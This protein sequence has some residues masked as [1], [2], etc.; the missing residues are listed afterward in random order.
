MKL[1]IGT[2]SLYN[3]LENCPHKAYHIY[4]LKDVP[5]VESPEMKW[6][7]DVHSALEH[8]IAD[9]TPLPE[10]MTAAEPTAATLHR[11]KDRFDVH[12][13]QKIGMSASGEPCDFWSADCWFRGK[14]DVSV[15]NDDFKAAW[16]LDW[17]TG[18]VREEP[19]EL[20][21]QALLTK[22][23]H[24]DLDLICGNYFWLQTGK[25]GHRYT[26]GDHDKVFGKLHDL[27][28]ELETYAEKGDW[29]KRKNPLCGWCPVMS[30][31][32]NKSHRRK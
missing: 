15:I 30:C 10:T 25:E 21:C 8:R 2:Y 13:E 32:N 26:L 28:D 16:L 5:Y 3:Q 4:V 17:K 20:E 24:P 22:V 14:L 12:V 7:N 18:K 29:P 9:G 6:G 27:R 31:E 11:L 19:F 1:P 23:N